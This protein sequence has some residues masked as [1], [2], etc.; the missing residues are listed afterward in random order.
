MRVRTLQPVVSVALM[1][2]LCAILSMPLSNAEAG[3]RDWSIVA[4]YTIPEGASGLAWDGS[5][6]YC[7]IYGA[8]GNQVYRI[9][10]STGDYTLLTTGPQEDAF[11]LT[12]DG[13]YLWTTD[14]AGSSSDPAVA[15]QFNMSGGLVSQFNLP[16]HYMSGIAYDGGDF[17]VATYY[18]DPATIYKVN[19]SGV[20]LDQF[21]APD[22]QPWDFCIE[23]SNL[24]MADYWGDALYLIDP[25]D[26]SLIESHPSDGVDPAGI[27]WDGQYL[28]YC[29][30][31]ADYAFD[32]LYKVDLSGSGTPAISFPYTQH[33]YGIV[34]VGSP[35]TW[36]ATVENV[37]T[38]NLVITGVSFSG[39]VD[40]SCTSTFPLTLLPTEQAQLPIVWSPLDFG[41]LDAIATVESNDPINPSSDLTLTGNAVYPGADIYLVETLHDYGQ[42][43]LNANT[44]WFMVIENRGDAVLTIDDVYSDNS[45]FIVDKDLEFPIDIAVLSS[46]QIGIWF[47]PDAVGGFSASLTVSSNDPDENPQGVSIQGEGIDIP[48]PYGAGLWE[49]T[50][51]TDNYDNSVKAIA[52]IEDI[53]DDGVPDVIICSEDDYIRCFNGN[54]HAH[55]DVLWEHYIYSGSVYS[56]V[57]LAIMDDIDMD[58][59]DDVV[60]GSAWGGKLIRALSGLTGEEIWTHYTNEYGGGA[61]VYQ[62]DCSYDYNGDDIRDV[63]ASTGDDGDNT[64]PRR[65]YCLDALTG[66]SIWECPT[67]GPGFSVIGVEDFTGDGQPDV[68]AGASVN[69]E[70]EARVYGINGETGGIEWTFSPT[71]SSVWALGQ[72]D[73]FTGDGKKDIVAGDFSFTTGNLYGLDAADGSQEWI[74]PSVGS[75]IRIEII[76]DANADGHPDV[77]PAHTSPTA[78]VVD[79]Q[80]GEVIWSHPIADKPWCL[81]VCPDIS[82]DGIEDLMVG[83]LYSSN[84]CYFLNG[85]DGSELEAVYVGSPVDGLAAIPDIVGDG[86]WEVVV[87]DRDGHVYCLSG[88]T[89]SQVVVC[90]DADGSTAIDIDDVVYLIAYIFASGPE[91]IPLVC[92]GDADGAAGVDIDDVVYLITYIFAGGPA[93]VSNCCG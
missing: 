71:G 78:K 79:G 9:D 33:N 88:G 5:Y 27:V 16:D 6:L 7:G 85:K 13:T 87:G 28:W 83:T 1:L 25:S 82:G 15:L 22:N 17:W 92:V 74:E 64:G 20:V 53:N 59:F 52:P 4:T 36:N 12:F 70:T 46:E 31:G 11:G 65:V 42:V 37:G 34:T 75:V 32:Y 35:G 50:I 90:G 21:T 57:G 41:A 48:Y 54:A 14:H 49:F 44:R 39:S 38:D 26:G 77:I 19:S 84:Y 24:W 93:P 30:N 8:N 29:D 2:A 76:A 3:Q 43:R 69:S 18:P 62:V 89:E 60:V 58:G 86:S 72:V 40:L 51:T 56:Q 73:D 81:D 23:N 80:T 91:P 68:V 47:R 61:W 55:G 67:N 63:L 10:P 45:R 66:V